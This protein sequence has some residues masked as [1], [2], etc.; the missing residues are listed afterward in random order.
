MFK[1]VFP[2]MNVKL[3]LSKLESIVF[4]V[5]FDESNYCGCVGLRSADTYGLVDLKT[6]SRAWWQTRLLQ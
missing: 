1:D 3:L 5:N 2:Y 4:A 6:G